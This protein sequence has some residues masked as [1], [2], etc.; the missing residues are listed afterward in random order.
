MLLM[1]PCGGSIIHSAERESGGYR[2]GDIPERFNFGNGRSAV[3]IMTGEASA[4]P[5]PVIARSESDAATPLIGALFRRLPR[6]FRS[7]Q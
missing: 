7:S 1:M 2:G 3:L 6:R 5:F 4:N